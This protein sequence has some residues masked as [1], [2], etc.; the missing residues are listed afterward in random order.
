MSIER[1]REG[2]LWSGGWWSFGAVWSGNLIWEE[3]WSFGV[4]RACEF[5]VNLARDLRVFRAVL[6]DFAVF[7]LMAWKA[8]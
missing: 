6:G 5:W 4:G 1:W 8:E 3:G 2:V 7:F